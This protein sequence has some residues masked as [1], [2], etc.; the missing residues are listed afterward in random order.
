MA[1]FDVFKKKPEPQA[2]PAAPAPATPSGQP[3]ELVIEPTLDKPDVIALLHEKFPEGENAGE[4]LLFR[5]HD[6]HFTVEFGQMQAANGAFNVQILLIARHP[7]FD[8]DLVE[9]VAGLGRTPDDAIRTAA[10]NIC[11]GVI[12]C[13]LSAFR[14]DA[15]ETIETSLMGVTHRFHLP[16]TVVTSHAGMGEPDDLWAIVRDA[17]PQYLGTKRV[18]WIKLFAACL[19]GIPECEARVNGMLCP[20][21]ADMLVKHAIRHKDEAGFRADKV[22]VVLIQDAA[23]YTPCPFTKQDAGELAFRAFRLFQNIHDEESAHK[24]HLTI[25]ESARTRDLGMEMVAFLPEIVAHTVIQYRDSESLMPVV[26]HGK[27]DVELKKTQVRSYGYIEDAVFQYLHKQQPSQDEIKQLLAVS[28]KFH[29]LS[30]AIEAGS[31]LEDL[32]LSQLVYFVD[33]YYR[34]W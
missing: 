23:T 34:V 3:E 33:E 28:S 29:A 32:R 2:Q 6:L 22:F 17:V 7:F 20:D 13:I 11:T 12:P 31:K 4:W 27:P 24:T 25:V 18:Y 15:P 1:L 21:L 10:E 30:Q 19:N 9:S 5:D 26:N 16:C 8:E 14:C